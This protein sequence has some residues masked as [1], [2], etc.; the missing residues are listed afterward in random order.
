[1][2]E[3][4]DPVTAAIARGDK[5]SGELIAHRDSLFEPMAAIYRLFGADALRACVAGVASSVIRAERLAA[6][7]A[8]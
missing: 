8:G 3:K 5:L 1:M 2:S 6:K 7:D 4:Q